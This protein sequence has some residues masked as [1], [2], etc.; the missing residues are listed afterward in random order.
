[1]HRLEAPTAQ[2]VLSV[3]ILFECDSVGVNVC[4]VCMWT[5]VCVC[6]CACVCECMHG[7]CVYVSVCVSGVRAG[8]YAAL[9]SSPKCSLADK[10]FFVSAIG[11]T[12]QQ[13]CSKGDRAH[14]HGH[15]RTHAYTLT[16]TPYKQKQGSYTDVQESSACQT[17]PA[18]QFASSDGATGENPFPPAFLFSF[19]CDVA[20]P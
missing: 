3:S 18:G 13:R 16:H 14:I 12:A 5:G 7:M 8:R 10:G 9:G 17:C 2:F 11:Q 15:G 4:G 20:S 19:D 6:A 1:M